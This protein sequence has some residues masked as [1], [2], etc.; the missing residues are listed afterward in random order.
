MQTGQTT[1]VPHITVQGGRAAIEFYK[2]AFGAEEINVATAPDSELIMHAVVRIG[3]SMLYLSDAFPEMGAVAPQA[4][5]P[6][7][8]LNLDVPDARAMYDQ[9]VA[10]GA[11]IKMP[12]EDTFWG[13]RYAQLA[14]PFGHMWAIHQ[15]LTNPSEAEMNKGAAEFYTPSNG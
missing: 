8:V 1:L 9:A 5:S 10:A 15:Q 14:D 6:A 13:A 12:I 2:K 7:F 4:P 11:T 3:Q